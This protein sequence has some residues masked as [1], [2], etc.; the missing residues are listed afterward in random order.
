MLRSK[1]TFF[2]TWAHNMQRLFQQMHI[3]SIPFIDVNLKVLLREAS[4]IIILHLH[5]FPL[6]AEVAFGGG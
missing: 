1:S 4:A 2:T 3:Q 6:V 5:Y